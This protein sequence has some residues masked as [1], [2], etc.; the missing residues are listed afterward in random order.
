MSAAEAD[1]A[2]I[3]EETSGDAEA[4]LEEP[5]ITPTVKR[6]KIKLARIDTEDFLIG[7]FG[8]SYSIEDFGVHPVYGARVGLLLTETFFIDATMGF[9]KAG[10]SSA[11]KLFNFDLLTEQERELVYYDVSVGYNLFPG[12]AFMG[13]DTAFVTTLYVSVGAGSTQFA[14]DDYFTLVGGIGYRIVLTDWMA[15]QVDFRD[16]IFESDIM[17]DAEIKHNIEYTIGASWFF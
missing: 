15:A 13:D 11:E 4:P 8:G 12:E 7:I 9:S 3:T 6:N 16:H 10:P 1:G 14:G 2:N 5:L 17:G